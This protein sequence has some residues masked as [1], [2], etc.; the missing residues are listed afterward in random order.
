MLRE[1]LSDALKISQKAKEAR[2]VSTLR[3]ILA[4]LKDRDIAA[5]GEG[6]ENGVPDEDIIAML[7]TM[8]R[9]RHEAIVLYERGERPELAQQEREEIDIIQEFLPIQLDEGEISEA[10]K[11][12]I[13]RLD[14]NGLKDMGPIMAELRGL[15]AGRMDFGR[16]SQMVKEQLS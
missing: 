14:A 5:R 9:Q 16:A 8:V 13:V 11:E 10:V 3:L 1:R 4:A 15:F 6:N 12:A 7:G 2:K